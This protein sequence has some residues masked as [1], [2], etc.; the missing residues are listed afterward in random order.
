MC[1]ASKNLLKIR[2][3]TSLREKQG[4]LHE[5]KDIII[6]EK[7]NRKLKFSEYDIALIRVSKSFELKSKIIKPIKLPTASK[8]SFKSLLYI[9][10]GWG[11][12]GISL[13]SHLK[14]SRLFIM[15]KERCNS[16]NKDVNL[17]DGQVCGFVYFRNKKS[18]QADLGGPLISN[19]KL[20][21][22][23]TNVDEKPAIFTSVAFHRDWIKEKT[24]I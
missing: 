19:K 10:T 7:Y 18:Y 21:G 6:H 24:G 4:D 13:S 3:A 2:S 23:L 16:L 15:E 17:R 8:K 14:A 20:L 5:I 9:I 22:I 11:L 12:D 1:R